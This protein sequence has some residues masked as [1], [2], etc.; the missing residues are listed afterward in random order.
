MALSTE[1]SI[2]VVSERDVFSISGPRYL[3]SVDWKFPHQRRAVAAC[4]VQAAYIL[5][6]DR[7]ENRRGPN[8][9]APAWWQFCHFDLIRTL[10]DDADCSIFGAI[11]ELKPPFLIQNAPRFVIAFRGTLTRRDS[12]ARDLTLDFHLIQ[13]SLHRSSRS[14]I[15]IQAVRNIVS[16]SGGSNIWLA[17][18]SLGS[19]M[20]TFCGK[21]MAKCGVLLEAFLFNPPFFSA[22]IERINNQKVKHGLRIAGSVITAGLSIARKLKQER[23]VIEDS[24]AVISSWV[25]CL[26]V[27]P[28]DHIC[29]E[30][31]GYFEHRKNMENLGVGIIEKLATQNSLGDGFLSA[32]G[33][34]S[35]SDPL[36]LLPS[37]ILSINLSPCPDFKAA[38]GLH[39]WW[40]PDLHLQTRQYMYN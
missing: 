37:A 16:A 4:L 40:Q 6:C 18:H 33:R 30:Y 17:G 19:A 23:P 8:A 3:T 38:H 11:F 27:N 39:Q 26:F 7:Q 1:Q 36:H 29:S 21:N 2:T 22:P 9:L 24:F 12:V 10:V 25:P 35:E 34:G 20:A 14:E 32:I 13:N 5:D 28:N 31:I 15:A